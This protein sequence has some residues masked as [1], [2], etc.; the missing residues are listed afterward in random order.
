MLVKGLDYALLEQARS[1]VAASTAAEDDATLEQAFLETSSSV[2]KKRTR[3][4]IVQELKAKRAKNEGSAEPAPQLPGADVPLEEAKKAGKFRPIGFKPVGAGAGEKA[5]KK[6]AKKAGGKEG[7]DTQKKT[8][9]REA[10]IAEA[11]ADEELPIP[12]SSPAEAG[13]SQPVA[14]P[15]RPLLPDPEPIDDD[16]DI[17]ADAGEY[18]GIDLGDDDDESDG[19]VKKRP[20]D[21]D[22]DQSRDEDAEQ[23]PP[24]GQ[25]FAT[26]DGDRAARASSSKSEAPPEPAYAKASPPHSFGPPPEALEDGEEEEDERPM[27]LQPLASSALP[28]IRD[29]LEMDSAAGKKDKW[30]AKKEKKKEKA[31]SGEGKVDKDKIDRDYKRLKAYTDKKAAAGGGAAKT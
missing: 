8:V 18:T 20:H 16:V 30:R 22:T 29:L 9:K 25:W 7:E 10:A 23:P 31:P 26:D 12:E 27:R 13:L 28:S 19:E 14:A 3:E 24:T 5:R 2:P 6:K 1:R 17:F 4:E 11:K 21:E 15:P